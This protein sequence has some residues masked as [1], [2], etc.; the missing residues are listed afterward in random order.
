MNR[1]QFIR[2]L[3]AAITLPATPAFI[4]RPAAAAL[5][6]AASP[7]AAATAMATRARYWAV[8]MNTLQGNCTPATLSAMLNIPESQAQ[9]YLTRLVADGTIR[10]HALLRTA[11]SKAVD[12]TVTREK[13]DA[14]LAKMEEYV[15]WQ[16]EG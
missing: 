13:A 8:Y 6:A 2:S 7:T 4:L 16:W 5:P 10:P 14:V 12:K 1:R 3:A 11:A 9:G 15:A